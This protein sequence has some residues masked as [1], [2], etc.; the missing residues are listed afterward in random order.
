MDVVVA[1][2]IAD[3]AGEGGKR[4]R[5]IAAVCHTYGHRV[6]FSVFECRVS[7]TR[8]QRLIGQLQ[9][10]IDPDLDSV[11][12]YRFPGSLAESRQRIGTKAVRELDEPWIL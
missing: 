12:I 6:Q 9:D 4:L 8:L 1:Y 3:T 10:V 7:P 2:D 5:R 11:M